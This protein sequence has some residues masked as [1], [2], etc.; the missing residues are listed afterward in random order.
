MVK[1]HV[2]I[3]SDL[4]WALVQKQN[5]F[6]RRSRSATRQKCFMSFSAEPNNLTAKHCFK[7]SGACVC[8][9]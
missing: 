7:D 6:V 5:V 1:S 3:S 8:R 9:G 2:A 4:T